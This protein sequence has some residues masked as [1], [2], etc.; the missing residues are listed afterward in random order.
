MLSA[1]PPCRVK[2]WDDAG[3]SKYE[4][5]IRARYS[6]IST[7]AHGEALNRHV[8]TNPGE[9]SRILLLTPSVGGFTNNDHDMFKK[10]QTMGIKKRPLQ[11]NSRVHTIR[12]SPGKSRERS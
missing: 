3:Y 8:L 11:D 12:I 6:A 1:T 10:L 9:L 5:S 2:N 4:Q 7:V